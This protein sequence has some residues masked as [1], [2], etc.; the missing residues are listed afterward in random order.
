MRFY[1]ASFVVMFAMLTGQA[2]AATEVLTHFSDLPWC[3][4]AKVTVDQA[5]QL[6]A[7]NQTQITNTLPT[8]FKLIELGDTYAQC[9]RQLSQIHADPTQQPAQLSLMLDALELSTEANYTATR[10]AALL[11]DLSPAPKR[12]AD[13]RYLFA[14]AAH[15]AL[16]FA[17]LLRQSDP[18]SQQVSR[19]TDIQSNISQLVPVYGA[20][21]LGVVY[22]GI[23]Q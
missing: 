4:S 15:G 8:T 21:Q 7:R 5:N 22:Q 17:S 3:T 23:P 18:R 11:I 2:S 20:D 16:Q 9:A 10:A 1:V 19:V 14:S 12:T 13:E 6:L